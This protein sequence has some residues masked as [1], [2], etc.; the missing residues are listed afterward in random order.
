M[1]THLILILLL[2]QLQLCATTY[3]VSAIG[4]DGNP[5]T[6]AAPFKTLAKINTM[7][8]QP[9]DQVLLHR[10]DIFR[11]ALD[12]KGGGLT[13][14]PI[15]IGAYGSGAAPII[16]GMLPVTSWVYLGGNIWESATAA[17]TLTTCETAA[18][19]GFT[20][21]RGRYPNTGYAV[22]GSHNSTAS[23]TASSVG[24]WGEG[25][26]YIRINAWTLDS[27]YFFQSGSTFTFRTALPRTP[28]DGKGFIIT[29]NPATLDQIG[30]WYFNPTTKKVRVYTGSSTTPTGTFEVPQVSDVVNISNLNNYIFQDLDL[31]GANRNV[32]LLNQNFGITFRNCTIHLAGQNGISGTSGGA[33]SSTN[34]TVE[35][36]LIRD[37]DNYGMDFRFSGDNNLVTGSTFKAIGLFPQQGGATPQCRNAVSMHTG[38]GNKITLCRFD[39]TGMAGARLRGNNGV[40]SY[41]YVTHFSRTLMDI[42][43]IYQ[44]GGGTVSGEKIFNNIVDGTGSGNAEGWGTFLQASGIYLDDNS[45]GVEVYNNTLF[46]CPKAGIYMHNVR[47]VT[48]HHNLCYN[49]GQA[50]IEIVKDNDKYLPLTGLEFKHNIPFGKTASQYL[51]WF[52]DKQSRIGSFG[53]ID[54]NYYCNPFNQ[55]G[56]FIQRNDYVYTTSSKNYKYTLAQWQAAFPIYDAHTILSPKAITTTDSLRFEYNAT[57]STVAIPLNQ[58]YVDAT[59][60]GYSGTLTLAPYTAKLLIANGGLITGIGGGDPGPVIPEP[61]ADSSFRFPNNGPYWHWHRGVIKQ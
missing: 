45:N 19:N 61:P 13:N 7:Y 59:G 41:N 40:V 20:A 30:E 11:G 32:V 55:N 15:T 56:A 37:C 58:T 43:G 36:C 57:N 33:S 53:V 8:L 26:M 17:T 46:N 38:S 39:S 9:G 21:P 24:S 34:I 48:A 23:I 49:N 2:M 4:S 22:I 12:L 14:N 52:Y 10:G 47:N 18:R 29:C 60:T 50:Q 42:G 5:G 27:M 16:S 3:Y 35:N 1:K 6:Q 51:I 25:K 28:T 44:A 31:Q 54:S